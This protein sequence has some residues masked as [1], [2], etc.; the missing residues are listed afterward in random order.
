MTKKAAKEEASAKK[1][2]G[3]TKPKKLSADLAGIAGKKEASRDVIKE[4][5]SY[6]KKS[7]QDL[8]NKQVFTPDKKTAKIIGT[9]KIRGF[10]M[11]KFLKM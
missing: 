8:E 4:L 1:T 5:W 9:E 3:F 6:L 7:L 11:A 10:G 2:K